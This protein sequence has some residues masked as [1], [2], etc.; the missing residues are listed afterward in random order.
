MMTRHHP[1]HRWGQITGAVTYWF[2][3]ALLT[4]LFLK[5]I[6]VDVIEIVYRWLG[7]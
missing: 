1:R 4:W 6:G 3:L 2:L 5:A 7:Q